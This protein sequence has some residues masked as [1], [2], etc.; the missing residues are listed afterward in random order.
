MDHVAIII[1]RATFYLQNSG[2]RV[3]CRE[4]KE[5]R[6]QREGPQVTLREVQM[7]ELQAAYA[8]PRGL[9]DVPFGI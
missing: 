1:Y 7:V 4:I 3:R 6:E 5:H 2:H 9:P 8:P